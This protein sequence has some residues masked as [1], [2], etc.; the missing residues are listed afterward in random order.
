I[1]RL[2][3]RSY[4]LKHDPYAGV[5][6]AD[7]LRRTLGPEFEICLAEARDAR[8]AQ[9]AARS[10][11]PLTA[12]RRHAMREFDA[13]ADSFPDWRVAEFIDAAEWDASRAVTRLLTDTEY[14]R[15]ERNSRGDVWASILY[16]LRSTADDEQVGSV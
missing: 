13:E 5:G 4:D 14:R 1:V 9:Q 10:A 11:S 16:A 2:D 6:I 15:I 8:I 3:A 12:A 7:R